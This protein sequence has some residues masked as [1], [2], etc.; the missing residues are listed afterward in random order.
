MPKTGT[1]IADTQKADLLNSEA[2]FSRPVCDGL[3]LQ[4]PPSLNNWFD[5]VWLRMIGYAAT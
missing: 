2:A 4:P 5:M 3:V 1:T